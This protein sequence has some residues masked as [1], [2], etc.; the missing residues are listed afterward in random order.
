MLW[1]KTDA[2]WADAGAISW[3]KVPRGG[4][5]VGIWDSLGGAT[6]ADVGAKTQ[7]EKG[8]FGGRQG[9]LGTVWGSRG[10]VL[11]GQD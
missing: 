7:C 10:G 1:Q 2:F 3:A 6:Y 4:H 9:A 11:L 5:I 8:C